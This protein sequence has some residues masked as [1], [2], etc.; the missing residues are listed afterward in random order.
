[1]RGSSSGSSPFS[2]C[3]MCFFLDLEEVL[4]GGSLRSFS[5]FS[6]ASVGEV[7]FANLSPSYLG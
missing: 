6:S 7:S 4:T 1:M 2:S 5:N 3:M